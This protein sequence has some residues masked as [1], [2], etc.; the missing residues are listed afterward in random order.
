MTPDIPQKLIWNPSNPREFAHFSDGRQE[1]LPAHAALLD[2]L[3]LGPRR[4]LSSQHSRYQTYNFSPTTSYGTLRN[5]SIRY[6]WAA[7]AAAFDAIEDERKQVEERERR[8]ALLQ[9]GLALEHERIDRLTTL[10]DKLYTLAT[11]N[12]AIWVK[13]VRLLRYPDGQAERIEQRRFNGALIRNLR[14]LLDDIATETG[15]RLH[16]PPASPVSEEPAFDLDKLTLDVLT[17]EERAEFLRL[18]NKIFSPISV[19]EKKS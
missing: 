10:F 16:R 7:R 19:A 1:T 6:E 5:W 18:Q 8:E 9:N 15:G 11:D 17:P 3:S 2:Y 14:G 4:T 13:D 12:D